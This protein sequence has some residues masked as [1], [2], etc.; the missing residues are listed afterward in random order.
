MGDM[1]VAVGVD[2]DRDACRVGVCDGGDGHLPL[3][4]GGWHAPAGWADSTAMGLWAQASIRSRLLGWRRQAGGRGVGPTDQL[5]G[6][7]PV[8]R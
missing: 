5:K 3:W 2:P 6:T 1:D 4:L 7:K 8:D